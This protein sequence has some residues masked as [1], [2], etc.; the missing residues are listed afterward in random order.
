MRADET[1]AAMSSQ[2]GFMPPVTSRPLRTPQSIASGDT[3][4]PPSV[5]RPAADTAPQPLPLPE[6]EPAAEA[7]E[8]VEDPTAEASAPPAAPEEPLRVL[9]DDFYEPWAEAAITETESPVE[10]EILA[11]EVE[12]A[13]EF[14]IVP[15]LAATQEL[16]EPSTEEPSPLAEEFALESFLLPEVDEWQVEPEIEPPAAV[17]EVEEPTPETSV[18][19]VATQAPAAATP[20]SPAH[21][22]AARFEQVAHDLREGDAESVLKRLAGGDRLDALLAGLL[23]GFLARPGE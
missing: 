2:G 10:P 23:A 14:E 20:S 19:D 3:I 11:L 15:E 9:A 17:P 21:D 22:L 7:A 8:P 13:S 1:D 16:E 12:V 4:A 5:W 18:D 6:P